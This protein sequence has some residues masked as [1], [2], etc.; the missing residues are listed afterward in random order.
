MPRER[1]AG[2]VLAAGLSSRMG[3]NKMLLQLGG[4][5]LVRRAVSTAL[6]AGLDPVVVVLGHQGERV[7]AELGGLPCTAVE[8][9]E[10]AR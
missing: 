7:R 1:I 6:S 5:S 4:T 8:N 3:T 2:V 10:Y 9:A